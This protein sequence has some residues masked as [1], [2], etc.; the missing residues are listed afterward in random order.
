MVLYI[1]DILVQGETRH[2]LVTTGRVYHSERMAVLRAIKYYRRKAKISDKTVRKRRRFKT[3]RSRRKIKIPVTII[4]TII[5][6]YDLDE[7]RFRVAETGK[8]W[9]K[10]EEAVEDARQYIK[11]HNNG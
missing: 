9:D 2:K 8:I 7:V 11:R 3:I 10:Y 5:K 4:P 6:Y 1:H